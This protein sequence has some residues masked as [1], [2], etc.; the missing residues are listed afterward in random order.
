MRTIEDYQDRAKRLI[1]PRIGKK[2][3]GDVTEA[4]VDRI[5]AATTGTRNRAYVA[6]LVKRST[7]P[8]GPAS[9]LITTAIPPMT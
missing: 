6:A 2:L 7:T 8:S 4:D 5:V 9:F 3:V 1:L